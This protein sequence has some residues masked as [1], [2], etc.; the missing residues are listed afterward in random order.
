MALS[1]EISN[2]FDSLKQ[3]RPL[4]LASYVWIDSDYPDIFRT[5]TRTIEFEPL[6]PE[7]LPLWD[8]AIAHATSYINTDLFIKPV[9]L[10]ND[11]FYASNRNKLVLCENY[12]HDKSL[13]NENK[14]FECIESF[15]NLK[16]YSKSTPKFIIEQYYTMF[17][18]NGIEKI[19][20]SLIERGYTNSKL[21][22]DFHYCSIGIDRVSGRNIAE[23]HFKACLYAGIRIKSF[24]CEKNLSEWKFEIGPCDNYDMAD[25]LLMA[26]F[27]LHKVAEDFNVVVKFDKEEPSQNEN[28]LYFSINEKEFLLK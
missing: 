5:K 4:Y 1:K 11:P 28:K 12:K 2:R 3:P 8:C 13:A 21:P 16:K 24:S 27:I 18:H 15:K 23:C 20:Q 19:D 26:R 6:K 10:F 9:K 25:E 14:R 7:D 22:K 17:D